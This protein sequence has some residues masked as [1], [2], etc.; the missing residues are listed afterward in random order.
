MSVTYVL[1]ADADRHHD[2]AKAAGATITEEL[3]ET[4]GDRR[5]SCREPQGHEWS[6]ALPVRATD[7]AVVEPSRG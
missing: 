5:Y 3:V 7:G 1:V 2:R 6:F 4:F